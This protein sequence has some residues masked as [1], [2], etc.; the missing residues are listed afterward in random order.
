CLGEVIVMRRPGRLWSEQNRRESN[1]AAVSKPRRA[2]AEVVA[3]RAAAP[4]T[5]FA[6][7]RGPRYWPTWLFIGW[8]RLTAALPWRVALELHKALGRLVGTLPT[9]RK[10]IVRR[11]LQMCFPELGANELAA[12][13][14]RHFASVGAFFAE[15]AVAWFGHAE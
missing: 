1:G 11:N 6:C 10:R 13:Q 15:L 2:R 3:L 8:L 14:S 9:R 5:V 4:E 12:L 7:C